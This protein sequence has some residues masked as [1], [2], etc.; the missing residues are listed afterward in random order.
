MVRWTASRSNLDAARQE[1]RAV[2]DVLGYVPTDIIRYRGAAAHGSGLPSPVCVLPWLA[3]LTAFAFAL[4]VLSTRIESQ[5][6]VSTRTEHDP[7]CCYAVV[8]GCRRVVFFG[9]ISNI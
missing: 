7:T 6:G 1:G 5:A 8:R 3:A 9:L 2:G 4:A